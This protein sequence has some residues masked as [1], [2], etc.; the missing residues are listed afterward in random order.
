MTIVCARQS[1]TMKGREKS[2]V[3]SMWRERTSAIF[4]D[5][6]LS[7]TV[8]VVLLRNICYTPTQTMR[9]EHASDMR[10][11]EALQAHART[12]SFTM[13][14][15]RGGKIRA[16]WK[17]CFFEVVGLDVK[18]RSAKWMWKLLI[19]F[20]LPPPS[21]PLTLVPHRLTSMRKEELSLTPARPP[22]P[23]GHN[24]PICCGN[25]AVFTILPVWK[26]RVNSE[27][28]FPMR[29]SESIKI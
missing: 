26:I 3:N 17:L 11:E 15:E 13:P 25:G 21:R 27:P 7:G 5:R 12:F 28:F 9:A 14:K 4:I 18:W 2:R 8:T 1:A 22:S 24:S 20:P 16:N 23:L 6:M 19:S 10:R 29:A